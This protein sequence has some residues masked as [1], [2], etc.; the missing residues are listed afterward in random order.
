MTGLAALAKVVDR[1]TRDVTE[2]I[3]RFGHARKHRTGS[4]RREATAAVQVTGLRTIAAKGAAPASLN[5][6]HIPAGV[7]DA[8]VRG[9]LLDENGIEIGGGLGPFEGKAWRS[10][11]MG[12]SSTKRN[13][14][15][16]L[17]ALESILRDA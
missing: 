6:V 4:D 8:R 13:V 3:C 10:G 5:A 7:D 15:L 2:R 16:L 11:L 17:A 14:T 1:D 12:S 9:R